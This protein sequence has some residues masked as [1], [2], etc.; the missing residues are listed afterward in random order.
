[1]PSGLS[2]MELLGSLGLDP[3]RVAVELDRRI[4]KKPE[5]AETQ[6]VAGARLEVVMFVGGG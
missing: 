1:V 5:W 2:L 4:V 3:D 6:I